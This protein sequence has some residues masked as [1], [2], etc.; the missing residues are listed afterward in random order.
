M[1]QTFNC[2]SCAAPLEYEGKPMQKCSFCESTVIV[3]TPAVRPAFFDQS[4]DLSA[5]TGKTLK[6]ARIQQAL[7]TGNKIEAIKI[8]RETFG[9]GLKEAKDAVEAMERGEGVD[10]SGMQIRTTNIVSDPKSLEA[11]KKIG[12]TI[13]GTILTVTG[14]IL[15]AT[16]GIII[17]VFYF[18]NRT[19]DRAIDKTANSI[20]ATPN[21]GD[22][23]QKDADEILRF[24]GD[25]IGAGRFKDNREVAIDGNGRIYS[26]DYN[27]G[28]IQVF[29]SDGKFITQ[30]IADPRMN[31]YGLAADRKGNVFIANNK[32]IF[33]YE[34]ESG[35]LLQKVESVNPR[36]LAVTLDG[37]IVYTTNKGIIVVDNNLKSLLDLKDAGER[38][39]A[40]GGFS[41][42]AVDGNG[43]IYALDQQNKDICKFSPD[44]K[45]LNRFPSLSSSPNAIAVD[46]KGRI[47]V[48]NTSNIIALDENGRS[49]KS[50][51]A[52][53]AFGLAFDD[54]GSL[55]VASRPFVVKYRLNF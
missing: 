26:A 21:K 41:A 30:W 14:L 35:K 10:V 38:A 7:S 24:G 13:G 46:P 48:A 50:F 8:F 52:T 3:P 54:Q 12:Y 23:K 1:T 36:G 17:S 31:L 19:I 5:L 27:G 43:N 2:P 32:G 34:G 55:L 29:D 51:G 40:A 9:T 11:V 42:V 28:R 49:L 53:Q 18:V 6:I 45:F 15:V 33:A 25:G 47:F 22:T 4:F 37:K 16:V 39:N 44:G 20:V